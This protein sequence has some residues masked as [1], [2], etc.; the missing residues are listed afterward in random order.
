MDSQHEDAPEVAPQAYPEVYH[1][2]E[3]V[4]PAYAHYQSVPPTPRK[5]EDSLHPG[6]TPTVN[7]SVSG[8]DAST[9][10][11]QAPGSIAVD[12]ENRSREFICGCTLL[13]FVLSLIIAV[14]AAAIVGLA[15]GVGVEANR[16]AELSAS[17]QSSTPTSTTTAPTATSFASIDN[18]CSLSDE[19]TTGQTYTT[20]CKSDI[21]SPTKA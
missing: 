9:L 20:Q 3:E 1:P 6:Y 12:D 10:A 11:Y 8:Y 17:I 4:T 7:P 16:L 18:N 13:V 21:T 15:A 5:L 14:L 19:T 2:P